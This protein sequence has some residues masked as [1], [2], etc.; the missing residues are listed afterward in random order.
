MLLSNIK[1]QLVRNIVQIPGWKTKRKIV[2]IQSDDWGSERMPSMAI[3]NSL[4]KNSNLYINDPYN[5]FDTLA[6]AEDLQALFDTLT[7]VKDKNG[8]YAKLTANVVLANP[9]YKKIEETEFNEYYFDSLEQ[10]FRKYNNSKALD[11]WAEGISNDLF[12]PQFHGREHV[13]VPF[14]MEKLK[15]GH[16]GVRLAF[17]YGVYGANFHDLGLRKQNF[18]AAW[19]FETLEQEEYIID[20][21]RM[22]LLMFKNKFGNYPKTVIAPSYTWSS[23]QE[24]ILREIGVIQ[25]QGI[26]FQKVPSEKNNR[27]K[28]IVRYSKVVKKSMGYQMRNVFF[29]PSLNNHSSQIDNVLKR[30]DIAFKWNKPAI[31]GS[32]RLN[33]IGVHSESNRDKTLE[34]FMIILKTIVKKWPDVEFMSAQELSNL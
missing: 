9:N 18:Q 20:S 10:T 34:Q 33:Y 12:V 15:S 11:L 3:H 6:S 17:E 28:K 26:L 7:C 16:K 32:H 2:V 27:Y 4:C 29:E 31:I 25:M 19:D 13:N 23:K 22:G 24:N 8:N 30:I 5:R 1:K 14:W 21:I